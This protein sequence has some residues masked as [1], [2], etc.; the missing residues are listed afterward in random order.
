[1]ARGS[2]LSLLGMYSW[3][4]TLFDGMSFPSG[5]SADDKKLFVKIKINLGLI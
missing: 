1:M 3:K 5:F 2:S 4:D